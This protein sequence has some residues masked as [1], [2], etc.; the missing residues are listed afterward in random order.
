MHRQGDE[1]SQHASTDPIIPPHTSQS[2]LEGSD[3]VC[4]NG[5]PLLVLV[6][7]FLGAVAEQNKEAIDVFAG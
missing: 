3:S 6:T 1:W 5:K 2:L 4:C 7:N